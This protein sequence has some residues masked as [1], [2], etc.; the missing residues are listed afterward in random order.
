MR[1]YKINRKMQNLDQ[2]EEFL[3]EQIIPSNNQIRTPM[4]SGPV[5]FPGMIE[6]LALNTKYANDANS[7]FGQSKKVSLLRKKSIDGVTEGMRM[8]KLFK[9]VISDLKMADPTTYSKIGGDALVKK[10]QMAT[11]KV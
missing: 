10:I 3:N 11:V 9:G 1:I 8:L 6:Y 5:E 2:F 7:N 4:Y